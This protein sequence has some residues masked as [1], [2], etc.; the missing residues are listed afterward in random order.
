M[1]MTDKE[2]ERFS[3]EVDDVLIDMANK[4]DTNALTLSAV[5]L[6]RLA[7]L[8]HHAGTTPDFVALMT[9]ILAP[10]LDKEQVH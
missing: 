8:N 5:I 3:Y 4:Y 1:S 9:D 2:L 6:A 7:L 10:K